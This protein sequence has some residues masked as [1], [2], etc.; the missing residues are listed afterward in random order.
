M[1]MSESIPE[2]P[3]GPLEDP[4]MPDRTQNDAAD[5]PAV[6]HGSEEEPDER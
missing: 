1:S 3:D 6:E 2:V 4:D 5:A